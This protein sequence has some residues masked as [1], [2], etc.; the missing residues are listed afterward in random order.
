MTLFELRIWNVSLTLTWHR[1][2]KEKV[3]D[4]IEDLL[5]KSEKRHLYTK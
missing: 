5:S 2:A 4:K 1:K 3:D